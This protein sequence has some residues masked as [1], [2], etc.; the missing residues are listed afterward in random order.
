MVATVSKDNILSTS[1]VVNVLKILLPIHDSN[2]YRDEA[3]KKKIKASLL[4]GGKGIEIKIPAMTTCMTKGTEVVHNQ[5]DDRDASAKLQ[6]DIAATYF[7]THDE[8]QMK[9]ITFLFPPGITCNNKFF[10][11]KNTDDTPLK[12]KEHFRLGAVSSVYK[13]HDGDTLNT[14]SPFVWWKMP[15]NERRVRNTTVESDSDSDVGKAYTRM[16]NLKVA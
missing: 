6:H 11:G 16:G 15:I 14:L 7:L 1:K 5:E 4:P 3:K 2:M 13:D 12:L 10:N 8:V 9:K